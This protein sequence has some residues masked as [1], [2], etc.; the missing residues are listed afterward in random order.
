M[1]WIAQGM[2]EAHCRTGPGNLRRGWKKR[3]Y[4][5]VSI[6]YKMTLAHQTTISRCLEKEGKGCK[7]TR[8]REMPTYRGIFESECCNRYCSSAMATWSAVSVRKS[9]ARQP[10]WGRDFHEY[11]CTGRGRLIR[12]FMAPESQFHCKRSI[13]ASTTQRQVATLWLQVCVGASQRLAARFDRL[14]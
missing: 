1:C 9:V 11:L 2:E 12:V 6:W 7:R 5:M 10:L 13:L 8:P 4:T 14:A 3:L